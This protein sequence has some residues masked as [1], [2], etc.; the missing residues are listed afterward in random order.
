M[1]KQERNINTPEIG[2]DLFW[3]EK[4]D[5]YEKEGGKQV[6]ISACGAGSKEEKIENKCVVSTQ[7]KT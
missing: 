4:A 1:L 2:S 6:F 7:I 3:I 5:Y